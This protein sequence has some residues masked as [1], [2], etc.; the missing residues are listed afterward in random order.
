MARLRTIALFAVAVMA[1]VTTSVVLAPPSSASVGSLGVFRGSGRPDL[2]SGYE[3]WLGQKVNYV[4]DYLGRQ[5][6]TSST[7]W[8]QIDDP[9]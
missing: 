5:P 7:P 6:T 3:Q 1:F 9:S 8:S 2:V 4:L